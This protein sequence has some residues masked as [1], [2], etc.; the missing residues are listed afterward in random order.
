VIDAPVELFASRVA[1][2]YLNMKATG[3]L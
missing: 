2:T 3:R 1:D